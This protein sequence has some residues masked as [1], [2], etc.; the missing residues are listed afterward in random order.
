MPP[1]VRNR[2]LVF[3]FD[4][5]LAYPKAPI[6]KDISDRLGLI[7]SVG[8]TCM[9]IITSAPAKDLRKR[10]PSVLWTF[11]CSDNLILLP[12]GGTSRIPEGQPSP[13]PPGPSASSVDS[14]TALANSVAREL[15]LPNPMLSM[16]GSQLLVS[17]TSETA[18]QQSREGQARDAYFLLAGRANLGVN[19]YRAG[20][21][22]VSVVADNWNKLRALEWLA[23]RWGIAL[24]DLTYMGD[25]F[26]PGGNDEP[27]RNSAAHVV[28]VETPQETFLR[29]DALMKEED[30]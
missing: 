21:R 5:T 19:V 22:S 26:G 10:I 28:S 11:A 4:G 29:V 17:F 1:D 8:R 18:A 24:E 27:I 7:L 3:D 13:E 14:L 25:D 15:G 20:Q 16:S 2:S 6:G 12:D 23:T 30:L 9:G